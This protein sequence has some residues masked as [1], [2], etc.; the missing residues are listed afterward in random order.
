MRGSVRNSLVGDNF[1]FPAMYG[2]H[3]F[4]SSISIFATQVVAHGIKSFNALGKTYWIINKP[5][6]K[7]MGGLGDTVLSNV[8]EG[9]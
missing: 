6:K 8:S 1:V 7:F 5:P 2:L 4:A 9:F 3:Q